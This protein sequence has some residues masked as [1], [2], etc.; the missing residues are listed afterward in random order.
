[1]AEA[2]DGGDVE[3]A[4]RI[5]RDLWPLMDALFRVSN[6]IPVKWAM[7][8]CGFQVG[9]CRSPMGPMPDA[10]K[11]VLEPLVAPFRP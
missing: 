8:T 1:M 3:T 9:P 4:A 5:H 6:P 11:T 10:L 7:S 2:F